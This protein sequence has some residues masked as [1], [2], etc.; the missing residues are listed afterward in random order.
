MYTELLI[1]SDIIRE[2]PENVKYILDFL[3]NPSSN[4]DIWDENMKIKL[5]ISLPDHEF[6]K[7]ERWDQIGRC[8]S[9]YHIP[10][11][12]NFFDGSYLFSRSDLKD[13]DNE[14]NF[15][16]DW[17]MPYLEEEE[18]KLL[19]WKWYEEWNEPEFIYMKNK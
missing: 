17:V 7:C 14:I 19:G 18:G 10:A 6:F 5:D 12:C 1:K 2:L 9:Y 15:F 13:Y 8:N 16:I 11:S 4:I 3:F